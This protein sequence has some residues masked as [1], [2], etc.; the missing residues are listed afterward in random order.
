[1]YIYDVTHS[2]VWHDL[3]ICIPWPM[4]MCDMTHPH[5]WHDSLTFI[6]VTWLIYMFNL[7]HSHVWHNPSTPVKWLFHIHTC[8]MTYLYVRRITFIRVTWLIPTCTW[9]THTCD[10]THLHSY[11]CMTYQYLRRDPFICVTRPIHTCD[12][13]HP[14]VWR[15]SF[16]NSLVDIFMYDSAAGKFSGGID[17][18]RYDAH[19]HTFFVDLLQCVPVCCSVLQCVAVSWHC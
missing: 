13:T 6:R 12:M 15:D 17:T 4:H 1:M 19:T 5:V 3:F 10:M 14:H 18:V 9:H 8:D 7:T 2:Y 11:V 16:T